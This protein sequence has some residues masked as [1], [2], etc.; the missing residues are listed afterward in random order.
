M[1]LGAALLCASLLLAAGS[2]H[3]NGRFPLS[4]RLFQ[5][6]SNPDSFVLSATFGLL[7]SRDGQNW[8]HVCEGMLTSELL[9]SDPL[10]ELMPDGS[11]LAGLVR[12]LL[13]SEDCG[14]SWQ[15]VLGE[16]E[17]QWVV[18]IAKAGASSVLALARTSGQALTFRL[19]RSN[20]G[21]RSWSKLSDL[22]Q[23]MQAFTLDAAPSNPMRVYVSAMLNADPDAGIAQSTPALF[24]S[25]DGGATWSTPRSIQ[26]ATPDD[27]AYIAAVDPRD[28]DTIY[29][30]TDA[31][32]LS[33]DESIDEANDALFVSD[34]A[35]VGFR[36]VLRRHAKLFGF[37]LSPDGATVA[38]GYGDP[39][40]AARY[41]YAEDT[42]IY[43]AS[44]AT[45]AFTQELNAE[46]SCLTWNANGLY[47]CLEGGVG[48]S[49]D[50]STPATPEGFTP[51]VAF[52][53][54][55]GPLA[56]NATTCLPQWQE[57]REDVAA[58]CELL[59]AVCEI[60]P[61][62][63][64]QECS[65]SGGR[66]GASTGGGGGSA[67]APTGGVATGGAGGAGGA[68]GTGPVT[69]GSPSGGAGGSGSRGACGCRTPGAGS[70]DAALSLLSVLTWL[71]VR[72]RAAA[73]K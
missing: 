66:A 70:R 37:A 8:Y 39:K 44:T 26:G 6:Q 46:V 30:R 5:D 68:G 23:G 53:D 60:D 38:L 54:V 73:R 42:G 2:S 31:W 56:C 33:E 50:G 28:P 20:D 67:G 3:A 24:V 32:T 64:V 15:P 43:R 47:A 1:R 45:L 59:D 18:D 25:D 40:Q 12:P 41:V 55:K 16:A 35:G 22:P 11:L 10:L 14:C 52:A 21:G 62:S 4:Q 48:L 29:V 17:D 49:A 19:E 63:N 9:E 13:R 7:V 72:R 34:D 27:F 51:V 71:V 61:A 36:E 69:G 57:G 65:P 58:T